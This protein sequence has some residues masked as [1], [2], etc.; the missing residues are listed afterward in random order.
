[1]QKDVLYACARRMLVGAMLVLAGYVLRVL[2]RQAPMTRNAKEPD[3]AVLPST[4][5]VLQE[6]HGYVEHL[7]RTRPE[8]TALSVMGSRTQRVHSDIVAIAARAC[9][10]YRTTSR[11]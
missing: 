4:V 6:T 7:V 3:F 11:R 8:L 10:W 9:T 5:A 2:H 1:M